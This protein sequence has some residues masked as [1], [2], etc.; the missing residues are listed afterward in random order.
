MEIDEGTRIVGVIGHPIDYTLSPSI[1]NA[2][3]E[4]MGLNWVY[5]PLRVPPGQLEPS[6]HGLRSLG[7]EGANVTIP[8]KVEVVGLVDGLIGDA[9]KLG[10]VNTLMRKGTKLLGYNT[11]VEGFRA[12]MRE[13]G[14]D[15]EDRSAM[16]IGAGGAARA[17]ALALATEG[18]SRLY[19]LNR[20]E[21]RSREMAAMLKGSTGLSEI[22]LGTFDEDIS[23]IL[24]DCE[25]LIN[26]TPLGSLDGGELP[27]EYGRLR[28]GVW[29]VDLKYHLR[30][31]G[32]MIEAAARGA[33]TANGEGMFLNQAAL[34]FRLWTGMAPPKEEMKAAFDRAIAVRTGES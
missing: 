25:L 12:F 23:G 27:I 3:F 19:I 18:I 30:E 16:V 2:A 10:A 1:H 24:G 22:S 8:H 13:K 11:D 9:A 7:F 32:F 31:T 33:L 4:S 26:C 17:V 5:L 15:C 20:T 28:N 6:I 34:S 29:A 14:I 21:K